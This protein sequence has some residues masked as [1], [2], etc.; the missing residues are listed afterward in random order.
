MEW[1]LSVNLKRVAT[2]IGSK[3]KTNPVSQW[4]KLFS[5]D[6]QRALMPRFN[7]KFSSPI[8]S[9]LWKNHL[10]LGHRSFEIVL[11]AGD[12]FQ[13]LSRYK[14][15]NKTTKT[16][17]TVHTKLKKN[18][19]KECPSSILHLRIGKE[20]FQELGHLGPHVGHSWVRADPRITPGWTDPGY[21][22]NFRKIPEKPE[23]SGKSRNLH[24]T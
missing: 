19:R 13:P 17:A 10:G 6:K 7:Y 14:K 2:P 15:L 24:V 3:T 8:W 22:G 18:L 12:I 1:G 5:A 16:Q 23:N 9:F 4:E 21:S 20:E 11:T